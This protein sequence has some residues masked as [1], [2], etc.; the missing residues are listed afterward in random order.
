VD[1]RIE[2][3]FTVRE[4]YRFAI[5]ADAFNLLNNTI[6]SSVNSQGYTELN[7][8]SG[9]CAGHA[10]AC[11]VPFPNFQSRTTTSSSVF[12][13]RQLQIGARFNF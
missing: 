2:R 1:F 11:L 9:S 3:A 12:G 6:V 8:G 13:A 10:N 5:L 4:R 7:P